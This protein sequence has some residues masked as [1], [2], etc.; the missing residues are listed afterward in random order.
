M[1]IIRKIS[2]LHGDQLINYIKESINQS[3]ILINKIINNSDISDKNKIKMLIEDTYMFDTYVGI[4]NLM[5][6]ICDNNSDHRYWLMA[7]TILKDHNYKF[8]TNKKLLDEIIELIK[9]TDN[10]YD[11]IFLS[12]M[13]RSMEKYGLNTNNA[14][15]VSKILIQLEQTENTIFNTLEKPLKIKIDRKKIDA[16]SD[17][18]MSSVYP[19]NNNYIF[20]NKKKYYYLLK[21]LSDKN[22]IKELET[23]YMKKYTDILPLIGKLIILR[24]VYAN[25]IGFDNYYL[26]C[27][28]KTEEETEHI[29]NL[30]TDLN[31]KLDDSF[32]R[33]INQLKNLSPLK[34]Q[35][36]FNDMINIID[37]ITPEIKL[38]PIEILQYVM[39]TIQKKFNIEFRTT[40]ISALNKYSNCIEIVDHTKNLKGYLHIDLL[41]RDTKRVNQ[42]S[43]IRLNNQ[44]ENNL[45]SVYLIGSYENLEKK[46][47]GYSELVVLFR[48]FGN[49]LINIFAT[50]P[51]GINEVD[52]EIFNFVP[53]I[54][55]FIAYDDFVLELVLHKIY[56]NNLKKKMTEIKTLRRLEL[57]INLKLKCANVLYDNVVHS[58]STFINS[59]K[60][61]ELEEI[62]SLFLNLNSK[63]MED[64][65]GKHSAI[66]KY[67]NNYINPSVINNLING[68]QG[69]IYGTVL[70][71][72]LSFTAYYL[73]INGKSGDFISKLL[74]NKNYSYRKMIMEFISKL[75]NDYYDDFLKYCLNI[76]PVSENYYDEDM[77]QTD[78]K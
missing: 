34:T 33:I 78:M 23:Q 25:H 57:I 29:Q 35:I 17:S 73:I 2:L 74:E 12:K 52:I 22:I 63:I 32:N 11:K 30:I 62:K 3:D 10:V 18:I 19:D 66:L 69:L 65:F 75:N 16:R 14:E 13:G 60:K 6:L 41:Q 67:Q 58:S 48:E 72:I 71:I 42:V 7:D 43:V 20:V 9:N 21:K 47:C 56:P 27:S 44:Y 4:V 49:I 54:M 28:E 26:M 15:R 77:T 38:S 76:E 37:K 46:S 51:N 5:T 40:T 36:D 39:V 31:I 8:N 45:P 50:T 55:E 1:D 24:N 59:I 53:D 70:S 61:V 68:N 64:I